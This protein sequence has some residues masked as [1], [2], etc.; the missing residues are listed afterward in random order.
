MQRIDG[1][2]V[3]EDGESLKVPM[4]LSDSRPHFA[5]PTDAQIRMRNRA[6]D[7]YV[8][9]T[10]DA[11][12]TAG[13]VQDDSDPSAA[14]NAVETARRKFTHEMISA[15]DLEQKRRAIHAE[16]TARLSNAWRSK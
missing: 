14:A 2:D 3:L 7:E 13:R 11:W 10:C 12:R 15:D 6:R 9:R 4:M 5:E 8:Q 1:I 16:F